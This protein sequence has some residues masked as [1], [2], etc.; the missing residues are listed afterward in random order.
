[1]P[2]FTWTNIQS[3]WVLLWSFSVSS[4]ISVSIKKT[5]INKPMHPIHMDLT[6]CH[7]AQWALRWPIIIYDKLAVLPNAK[8]LSIFLVTCRIK[9]IRNLR[10]IFYRIRIW[11]PID[12]MLKARCLTGGNFQTEFFSVILNLVGTLH[13]PP[14][15]HHPLLP[16]PSEDPWQYLETILVVTAGNWGGGTT[17]IYLGM[18]QCTGQRPQQRLVQPPISVV[19]RLSNPSVLLTG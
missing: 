6:I 18:L 2:Q 7:G 5:K 12:K 10:I 14:P 8:S 17:G 15:H 11:I 19:Q 16:L 4:K 1:M 9:V 3:S 13:T